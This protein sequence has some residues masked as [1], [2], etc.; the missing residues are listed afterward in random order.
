MDRRREGQSVC[1]LMGRRRKPWQGKRTASLA[2]ADVDS[3]SMIDI[4]TVPGR[5]KNLRLHSVRGSPI[6][7]IILDKKEYFSKERSM[8]FPKVGREWGENN[9]RKKMG[10][11]YSSVSS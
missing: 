5:M 3:A 2:V 9:K 1:P 10:L 8:E 7:I 6:K 4:D 11:R